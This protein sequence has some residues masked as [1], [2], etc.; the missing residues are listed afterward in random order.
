[1]HG[2]KWPLNCTRTRGLPRRRDGCG[3][4]VLDGGEVDRGAVVRLRLDGL[5]ASHSICTE[6]MHDCDLPTMYLR[7]PEAEHDD[8]GCLGGGDSRRDQR[9][10]V[11]VDGRAVCIS[12]VT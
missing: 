7:D 4:L 12:S 6:S 10:V 8:I 2:Y 9:A 3:K 5:R 11:A 1:M